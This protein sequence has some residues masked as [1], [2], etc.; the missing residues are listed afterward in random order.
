MLYVAAWDG[1]QDTISP[2]HTF[3]WLARTLS[4]LHCVHRVYYPNVEHLVL[5]LAR[6][7]PKIWASFVY[8]TQGLV[9]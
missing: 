1:K 2:I 6:Y 7:I 9:S 8:L 5:R 4:L 3:C